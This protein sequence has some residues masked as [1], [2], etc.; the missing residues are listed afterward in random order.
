MGFVVGLGLPPLGLG[1]LWGEVQNMAAWTEDQ[2][3]RGWSK[4]PIGA[5]QQ[6]RQGEPTGRCPIPSRRSKPTDESAH[7]FFFWC[8]EK[9]P[10]S[11]GLD[12]G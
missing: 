5:K 6:R 4:R 12:T 2:K 1:F 9:L 7:N 10:S 8:R 3:N 11:L